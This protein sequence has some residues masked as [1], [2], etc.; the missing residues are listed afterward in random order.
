MK[1]FIP[2][3]VLGALV[4]TGVLLG[5]RPLRERFNAWH[6]DFVLVSGDTGDVMASA[7]YQRF[8]ARREAIIAMRQDLRRLVSAEST[9][10]ADSGRPTTVLLPPYGFAAAR[11]NIGPTIQIKPD[12]WIGTMT[13]NSTTM[14]CQ[15]TSLLDTI[16][17]RYGP[18]Q[19]EC[20]GESAVDSA[21]A[22]A[23]REA[24]E[25]EHI[26]PQATPT[27]AA[28]TTELPPPPPQPRPHR[29]WGPVNN[30]PPRTPWIVKNVCPGEYCSLG[31]WAACS[32]VVAR[33]EAR[34][35]APPAFALQPG[36][37]FTALSGDV[38]VDVAGIVVFRHPY[39]NPGDEGGP[40]VD[41]IRF[42]PTDTLYVLN[43]ISEGYL[44]W[45]YRGRAETG[46]QFWNGPPFI[47]GEAEPGDT[48]VMIR[49][50][51][52]VWWVRLRNAAGREGW[53]QYDYRKMARD[54]RMD[55]LSRCVRTRKG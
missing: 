16:R 6:A 46:Y 14:M 35:Q 3:L 34:P 31:A 25:Q 26:A 20:L 45:Y 52:E 1:R 15:V 48:A 41:S 50:P 55:E 39:S 27:P 23:Q 37:G 47:P 42:L 29:D 44:M 32:T 12:R 17:M 22:V 54:D 19:I 43:S 9:F 4:V 11:G 30:T 49:P 8:Q 5:A 7:T 38:H 33:R 36:E 10:I 13:N 18:G 21:F 53:V 24:A 40:P 28:P 51:Q 2:Y